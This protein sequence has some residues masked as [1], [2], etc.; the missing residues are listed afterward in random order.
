M[1]RSVRVLRCT[2]YITKLY[3]RYLQFIAPGAQCINSIDRAL[4]NEDLLEAAVRVPNVKIFFKHKVMSIDFDTKTMT[5]KNEAGQ[6][7]NVP[8]DFCIGADGSYS[9]VRRQMMRVLR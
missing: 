6:E 8:F 7:A 1:D 9:L 2:V 3:F 4:L 5:A